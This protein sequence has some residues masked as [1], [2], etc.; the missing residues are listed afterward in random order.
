[1]AALARPKPGVTRSPSAEALRLWCGARQRTGELTNVPEQ[2]VARGCDE[3][4]QRIHDEDYPV[5]EDFLDALG[6]MPQA[7]W[8]ALGSIGW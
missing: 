5:D 3:G 2:R 7:W 1:L 6:R 8:I 4:K